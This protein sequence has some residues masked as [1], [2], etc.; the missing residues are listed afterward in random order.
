MS[1]PA[2]I[3]LE[4]ARATLPEL[5]TS[6]QAGRTRIITRHG[7]P[8]AALVPLDQVQAAG[9]A[10]ALEL[11]ALRGSGRGLWGPDAARTVDALRAEWG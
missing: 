3:G 10:G 5:V 11:I 1:R 6:A 9:S 7:K 4:Q 8:A 2:T